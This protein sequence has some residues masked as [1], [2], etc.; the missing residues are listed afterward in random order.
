MQSFNEH[1]LDHCW[2]KKRVYIEQVYWNLL[3]ERTSDVE[4]AQAIVN[5]L[6]TDNAW[7]TQMALD[8]RVPS[9]VIVDSRYTLPPN[10]QR[11]LYDAVASWF[12]PSLEVAEMIDGSCQF[13]QVYKPEDK[14]KTSSRQD[15]LYVYQW[16][17]QFGRHMVPFNVIDGIIQPNPASI[18]SPVKQFEEKLLDQFTFARLEYSWKFF[19]KDSMRQISTKP[20]KYP[21][22]K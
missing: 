11:I 12:E 9:A 13:I 19:Q 21:S 17:T 22:S 5:S 1:L 2:L 10:P 16:C 20:G 6:N 14:M 4:L 3:H 18:N 7:L 8:L 15:G